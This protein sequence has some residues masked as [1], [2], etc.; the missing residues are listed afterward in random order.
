MVVDGM[1]WWPTLDMENIDMALTDKRTTTPVKTVTRQTTN[2]VVKIATTRFEWY[3]TW[4][5]LSDWESRFSE[6]EIVSLLLRAADQAV[7]SKLYRERTAEQ[8]KH[9][10]ALLKANPDL[11]DQVGE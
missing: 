5:K 7:R 11:L 6:A 9:L 3:D 10:K 1:G 2:E 8:M 4:T